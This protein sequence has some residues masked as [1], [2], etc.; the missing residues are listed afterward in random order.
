[1]IR[2]IDI[3]KVVEIHFVIP[4]T[5]GEMFNAHTHGLEAFGHKEFQL[6]VPGFCRS[7]AADILNNHADR[8]INRREW[9]QAGDTGEVDGMLCAYLEV[10]GDCPGDPSRLR[11]AHLPSRFYMS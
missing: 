9:F 7:A 10:P 6:L 3:M 8:V 11:I 5:A 2:P 1:M 4:D